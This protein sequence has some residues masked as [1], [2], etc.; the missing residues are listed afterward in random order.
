MNFIRK[1]LVLIAAIS[2]TA[3]LFLALSACGDDCAHSYGNWSVEVSATCDEAGVQARV[4]T[5]CG[6]RETDSI[7]AKGHV[8]SKYLPD[9]NESCVSMGTQTAVC[10]HEGCEQTKTKLIEGSPIGHTYKSG[11]CTACNDAMTLIK[12]YDASAQKDGSVTVKVYKG[13]DGHFELDVVGNG[14]MADFSKEA[15]PEWNEYKDTATVIHVYEGVTSVG[16]F[17]FFDFSAIESVFVEKGVKSVGNSAFA[18]DFAPYNVFIYDVATWVSLEFEDEGIPS[19]YRTRFLYLNNKVL[20]VLVIDEGITKINP[21]AFYGNFSLQSVTVPESL[22]EIGQYAFYGCTA[23]DEFHISSLES[24]C[25]VTLAK[26]YANPM[27]Y[28][29]DLFINDAYVTVLEIPATVTTIKNNAFEGCDSIQEVVFKGENV[30]IGDF[31]FYECEK[32]TEID[33]SGVSAIGKWAFL[34]CT[35]LKRLDLGTTVSEIGEDAFRGCYSLLAVTVPE[36]AALS[37]IGSNA[38]DGCT[39]LHT[40]AYRGTEADLST[41]SLGEQAFPKDT[42]IVTDYFEVVFNFD[43]ETSTSA[44]VT[45]GGTVTAPEAPTKEGYVLS[46]WNNGDVEWSFDTDTV[47]ADISLTAVWTEAEEKTE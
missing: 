33:F 30:V 35:A 25:N 42:Q 12:T 37:R 18:T 1:A 17:S 2:L 41:I 44:F 11:V 15:K 23:L 28:A 29:E 6:N 16:D 38:F 5:L 39:A 22:T 3:V 31:A 43:E 36:G 13:S 20:R 8:F 21:Y 32:I 45:S 24:W 26:D 47:T 4:C 40:F 7:K 10:E 9:D 46:A 27:N 34:G 19:L 14:V